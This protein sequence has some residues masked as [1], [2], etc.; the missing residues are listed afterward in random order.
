MLHI[1]FV[2]GLY[3]DY[4]PDHKPVKALQ[5]PFIGIAAIQFRSKFNI[6]GVYMGFASNL[7][8]PG[9]NFSLILPSESL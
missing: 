5:R 3:M 2:Y 6:R 8:K 1:C 9:E 7:S 4:I